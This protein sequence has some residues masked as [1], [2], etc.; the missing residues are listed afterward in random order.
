MEKDVTKELSPSG[1]LQ[2][3]KLQWGPR[4]NQYSFLY[5]QKLSEY[6]IPPKQATPG[7]IGLDLYAPVEFPIPPGEQMCIPIDLMLVPSNGYYLRIASKS[8][9]VVR[10]QITRSW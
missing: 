10:H 5:Y 4:D 8:G 3:V 1:T 2:P 6:A 7:S 9:L